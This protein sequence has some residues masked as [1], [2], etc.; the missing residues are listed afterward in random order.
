MKIKALMMYRLLILN[1]KINKAL[2]L[3]AVG[4]AAFQNPIRVTA[5]QHNTYTPPMAHAWGRCWGVGG[6]LR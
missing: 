6:S 4:V 2:R 1:A 5:Q 3:V